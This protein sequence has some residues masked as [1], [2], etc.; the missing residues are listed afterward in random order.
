[1]GVV[2][3]EAPGAQMG[4]LQMEE[5]S[6]TRASVRARAFMIWTNVKGTSVDARARE[7]H[8]ATANC[9]RK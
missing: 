5:G 8:N 1:M 4:A 6:S 3:I 9:Q 7:G 2:V